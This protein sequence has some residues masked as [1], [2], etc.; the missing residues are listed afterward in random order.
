VSPDTIHFRI[1]SARPDGPPSG[2]T[3]RRI[4][5]TERLTRGRFIMAAVETNDYVYPSVAARR[6]GLDPQAVAKLAR[7]GVI[8]SR[9]VPGLRV[10]I[11]LSDLLRLLETSRKPAVAGA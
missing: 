6:T 7:N 3:D 1:D 8:E 9:R 11:K 2:I 4:S 10:Q 5:Q